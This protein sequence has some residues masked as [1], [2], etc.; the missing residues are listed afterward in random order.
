MGLTQKEVIR[1]ACRIFSMAYHSVANY[2]RP[3]DGFCDL[4]PFDGSSR[5]RHD[6]EILDYVRQAVV[7]KLNRDGHKIA[8]GYDPDTGKEL[9][10]S[11]EATR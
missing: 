9:R 11:T 10:Y 2:E 3:S 6:G 4:C 8:P 5:F 7:E 1:E